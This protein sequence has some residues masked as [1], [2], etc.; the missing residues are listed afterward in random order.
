M[1]ARNDIPIRLDGRRN[2]KLTAVLA[3]RLKNNGDDMSWVAEQARSRGVAPPEFLQDTPEISDSLAFYWVAFNELCTERT[4]LGHIPIRALYEYADRYH[5]P[6]E[7]FRA[8]MH[9]MDK[10]WADFQSENRKPRG[11]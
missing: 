11:R 4:N 3:F 6:L 1:S 8:I 7:T 9:A 5:V 10:T 2:K